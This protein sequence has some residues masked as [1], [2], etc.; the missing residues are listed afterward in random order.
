[1][2]SR[3]FLP[4]PHYIQVGIPGL[5]CVWNKTRR[6]NVKMASGVMNALWRRW[7]MPGTPKEVFICFF[8]KRPSP[9]PEMYDSK[10][11]LANIPFRDKVVELVAV[12]QLEICKDETDYLDPS[13]SDLRPGFVT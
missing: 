11:P 6:L 12:I 13:G 1:M 3:A 9:D 2:Q 5:S 8:L 7:V 10:H 4:A